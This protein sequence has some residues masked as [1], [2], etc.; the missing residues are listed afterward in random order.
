MIYLIFIRGSE[1]SKNILKN[2]ITLLVIC[3]IS[4]LIL[5]ADSLSSSNKEYE[6]KL[7][8]YLNSTT[9][10]TRSEF[11]V[12]WEKTQ[13]VDI[14]ESLVNASQHRLWPIPFVKKLV[15]FLYNSGLKEPQATQMALFLSGKL[16]DTTYFEGQ[17][18]V[19]DRAQVEELDVE[20]GF[21]E[22]KR[23]NG[24][25]GRHKEGVHITEITQVNTFIF[26]LI[27]T[28]GGQ[29]PSFDELTARERY[30]FDVLT[31]S[32]DM[33]K[34][35]SRLGQGLSPSNIAIIRSWQKGRRKRRIRQLIYNEDGV[36]RQ[37]YKGKSGLLKLTTDLGYNS[38][39]IVWDTTKLVVTSA[40][41]LSLKYGNKFPGTI[42]DYDNL[43][44]ILF[45]QPKKLRLKFLGKEGYVRFARNYTD[46]KMYRAFEQVSSVY[47]LQLIEQLR[48]GKYFPGTIDEFQSVRNV[49]YKGNQFQ[50]RFTNLDGYINFADQYTN[51]DMAKAY[52]MVSG[53]LN[54]EDFNTLNW[55]KR[56]NGTT[57]EYKAIRGRIF[58]SNGRVKASL[59]GKSGLLKYIETWGNPDVY[60]DTAYYQ[61]AYLLTKAE[62][63]KLEWGLPFR[64]TT[65]KFKK[66]RNLLFVE[67][68][69]FFPKFK[70][71]AGYLAF[72]GL[73]AGGDMRLAYDWVVAVLTAKEFRQLG[74]GEP[75]QGTTDDFINIRERLCPA[76]KVESLYQGRAGYRLY[77]DRFTNG[78][79]QR[80]YSQM[81]R[82]LNKSEIKKLDWGKGF[83][84][85]TSEFLAIRSR[86]FDSDGQVLLRYRNQEGYINYSD[87]Y[88]KGN[89]S[90]AFYQINTVLDVAEVLLLGWG[91]K[92]PGTTSR[93]LMI[94]KAFENLDQ[95]IAEYK[96]RAGYVKFCEI[97]GHDMKSTHT[98]VSVILGKEIFKLLQ[99]GSAFPGT[100]E[101]FKSIRDRIFFE[102]GTVRVEYIGKQGYKLFA[103]NYTGGNMVRAYSQILQAFDQ[104]TML[105]LRW[106]NRFPGTTIQFELLQSE[107]IYPN[108]LVQIRFFGREGYVLFA[109]DHANGDM[110]MA[111]EMMSGLVTT[112]VF[113]QLEWGKQFPGTIRE[114]QSVHS[115]LYNPGGKL[116]EEFIGKKGY[117]LYASKYCK[118]RMKVAF[119]QV[120]TVFGLDFIRNEVQWGIV[121]NR[122]ADEFIVLYD[123]IYTEDNTIKPWLMNEIGQRLYAEI[124]TDGNTVEAYRMASSILGTSDVRKTLGW[125]RDLAS[126]H[127]VSFDSEVISE[128]NPTPFI[129]NTLLRRRSTHD[130][131]AVMPVE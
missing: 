116:K 123:T 126:N 40:E 80:A 27:R 68:N 32:L 89:M 3:Q 24:K 62:F 45:D 103:D 70:Q 61:V 124:Y 2:I 81:R 93:F 15:G 25:K 38:L 84:G 112:D 14:S 67:P 10:I 110:K 16:F 111:Y 39:A 130:G 106:G 95:A 96:S 113:S 55:K 108:G 17:V 5:F 127:A 77:A 88:N 13:K 57:K 125:K 105:K 37:E 104:D 49:F 85:S 128:G 36:I 109:N 101:A 26:E 23:S 72:S 50:L 31:E 97:Y 19:D 35:S 1:R 78:N 87:D 51:G 60:M 44:Y 74:W 46:G 100:V 131:I 42:D 69:V 20:D 102:N 66:I 94:K 53:V 118:E 56:F 107:V 34:Y 18:V 129:C 41:F 79:M 121:F 6:N 114:Y 21:I 11:D 83:T 91:R 54:S 9:A 7:F 117:Y 28:Y 22:Y 52:D 73:H 71:D 4:P 48:W 30:I 98:M 8:S 119:G 43:P 58:D 115:R 63:K 82:V 47:G 120:S 59:K 33:T 29:L 99:W 75:F 90:D 86:V 65:D 92:F 122:M 76:N 64:G 12:K